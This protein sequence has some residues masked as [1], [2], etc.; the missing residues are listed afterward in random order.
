[1]E[2]LVETMVVLDRVI[3]S[4]RQIILGRMMKISFQELNYV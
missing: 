3:I 4:L 1:M 2:R